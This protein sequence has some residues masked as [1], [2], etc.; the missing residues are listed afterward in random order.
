MKRKR[1]QE[2]ETHQPQPTTPNVPHNKKSK[3]A[4]TDIFNETAEGYSFDAV[5]EH[6]L[7]IKP[8]KTTKD[9]IEQ[10]A[11][12][13]DPKMYIPKRGFS[14]IMSGKSGSGKS[15]LLANL[16]TDP[17]FYGK[18]KERPQGWFDKIF[19]FSPTANGDDVQKSLNIPK[20]HVFTDL[21]E[22]PELLEIILKSQQTKLDKGE[23]AHKVE[24]WAVIFDDFIGDTQF[25]NEATFT[26]CFYMVR[27]MNLTTF[28]CT[29]HFNRVPRVCRLQA[30]FIFFF[31]GSQSEVETIVE[32]FAPPQYT[33]NEFRQLVT[34]ATGK[35]NFDFLTINMKVG[36][37][38]RF[39]RNLDEFIV[40]DRLV[41][42]EEGDKSGDSS[43][44]SDECECDE[45]DEGD[46]E[47][48]EDCIENYGEK[49]K[50]EDE[51]EKESW[52]I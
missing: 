35:S 48:D 47:G 1:D 14:V 36:W 10:P 51:P 5:T 33:K 44:S 23:G 6:D 19:L 26:K 4:R 2:E 46:D 50:H 20:N 25:M 12:A 11:L 15:T 13:D 8:I 41:K 37:D 27:H 39:R 30:N 52:L 16:L 38:L 43:S 42:P 49:C 34:D 31:Q 40:L 45:G 28:A 9:L 24:Q 29:Q 3:S 7:A 18:S 17:R 32:E 22:A 21:E